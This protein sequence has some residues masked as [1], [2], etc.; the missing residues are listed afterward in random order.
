MLSPRMR[1]GAAPRSEAGGRDELLRIIRQV[2]NRW[3]LRLL[4]RGAAIV[5]GAGLLAVL[6]TVYGL[7]RFRF[8]PAAIIAARVIAYLTLVGLAIRF[9]VLPLRRK[10]SDANV[11]LYVE[12]HEPSLQASVLTAVE[13]E[14][15]MPRRQ[16]ER[17]EALTRRVV[18]LA[19]ART[20]AVEG[21]RRIERRALG[22]NGIALGGALAAGLL[23]LMLGPSYVRHGARSI[24][25][26]WSTAAAASPYAVDVEPGHITIARGADQQFGARLRGFTSERVELV[27]RRGE[28]ESWERVEMM[29]EVDTGAYLF[30]LFDIEQPVEYYVE[31]NGVR[32]DMFR[33]EVADL[34]FVQRVDLEYRF[35]AYTGLSPQVIEETGDIAAI[36]GTRVLV[37]AT[38]T[39]AVSGG[40]IA[41]EGLEPIAMTLAEDGSLSGTIEVAAPGYYKIELAGADGVYRPASVDYIIDVLQDQPPTIRF[42]QPGRDTRV[43]SV[44]EVFTEIRAEDDYGIRS[45]ELVYSVNGGPEKTI[46]LLGGGGRSLKELTAGH[47]FFL[48]EFA[49]QP[50][51]VV[52]Y[53]ARVHDNDRVSGSRTAAT[54]IYFLDIRPF[55]QTYRQQQG[56]GGGGGG[57]GGQNEDPSV[58]SQQQRD[59]V[60]ATFKMV[61]DRAQYDEKEYAENLTTLALAQGRLRERVRELAQRMRERGVTSMDTTFAMIADLLPKAAEEMEAAEGELGKRRAQEALAPEQRALQLL[62]RAEAAYREVMV[63]FGQ[64]GGGGGGGGQQ[65][66]RPEDLADLF[67][68]EVDRLRNQY[69]SVQRG[70]Q[71]QQSQQVDE[72]M[73]RLRQLAARQQQEN[74]RA[75][76]RANQLRQQTGGAAGGG[77]GSQRELAE[78]T[79]EAARQL[80]R[81]ARERQ[82]QELADAARRLQQSAEAMRRSAAAGGNRSAAE[83]AAALERLE[84][85]RRLM[86][87][88]RTQ[89]VQSGA[90]DALR[91]IQ[92]LQQQQ[93]E[94][95]EVVQRLGQG[96]G[97]ERSEQAREIMEQKDELTRGVQDVQQQLDRMARESQREQPAASRSLREGASS[98]RENQVA[99]KIQYGKDLINRRASPAQL[100]NLEESITQ[101][102]EELRGHVAEATQ[103]TG[104]TQEQR[105]EGT[106]D[107]TRDLV[108]GLESLE[109]R[110]D[111]RAQQGRRGRDERRLGEG[112]DTLGRTGQ[113]GQEGQGQQGQQ[114][115]GQQGQAQGQEGQQGQQGQGQGQQG[116]EGQGQGEGQGQQGQGQQGQGGGQGEGQEGQQR[117][118][119]QGQG[120]RLDGEQR[121]GQAGGGRGNQSGGSDRVGPGGAPYGGGRYSPEEIRQYTNE[122]GQRRREAEAIRRDLR[123]EGQDVADLD[124]LIE[125]MRQLENAETFG[126]PEAARRLQSAVVEGLKTYEYT[127]RRQL[128]GPDRER[129]FLGGNDDVPTGFRQ[130]V[131]EYYRSLSNRPPQ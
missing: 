87:R 131:E 128:E 6:I 1:R 83:A 97:A 35:P 108:Q 28:G 13:L 78:Q 46:P 113:G 36:K 121:S 110:M 39:M 74:E 88:E 17:S 70:E 63:Q 93:R 11:A 67:E 55:G 103:N 61:R 29:T 26:P 109:E 20:R 3:R 47:T 48:E 105:L 54:D 68:L 84:D 50:G 116:Q 60:A 99:E 91:R 114:G 52:S 89:R 124:R 96:S 85:A 2:R 106:L 10:V 31:S 18:E 33:V 7:E 8:D 119:G 32:S 71:E 65:Q 126:D 51:D 4:V 92:Q 40:R 25:V 59:I 77:G 27:F 94:I 75:R 22:Q 53:Y 123:R 45:A 76:E 44:D 112:Q 12:E 19:L 15:G 80:E 130:L 24:F 122:Y 117:G 82:S 9:L 64:Q 56:G 14:G 129:L 30:R 118:Q 21:G 102:L 42:T 16:T 72:L 57:G 90:D 79:E 43:T 23:V 81:L 107:R 62:Q 73:E 125:R 104:P 127:L 100:Q 120:G 66:Q 95:A 69:E 37:K 98:I 34:P 115:E 41:I 49:L 58:L 111:E 86:D 101:N 38:P 5:L